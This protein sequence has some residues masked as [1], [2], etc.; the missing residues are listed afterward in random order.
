MWPQVN[1]SSEFIGLAMDISSLQQI[2]QV[3]KEIRKFFKVTRLDNRSSKCMHDKKRKSA[4][5]SRPKVSITDLENAKCMP[6]S[7]LLVILGAG[8]R[9]CTRKLNKYE[10]NGE[11]LLRILSNFQREEV[12]SVNL[13]MWMKL[14]LKCIKFSTQSGNA[15][16]TWC[17][18][19]NSWEQKE[20][21]GEE[22]VE[23]VKNG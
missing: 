15:Y 4:N 21:M 9:T 22:R 23:T 2:A 19:H 20:I 1:L 6:V 14:D 7:H 11:G 8:R 12:S 13:A 16:R 5:V 18:T 17:L 10:E 3:P